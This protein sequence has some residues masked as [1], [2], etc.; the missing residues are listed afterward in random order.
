MNMKRKKRFNG[1][2]QNSKFSH[3]RND[4]FYY[5]IKKLFFGIFITLVF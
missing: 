5:N 2:T 4:G 3:C 1:K